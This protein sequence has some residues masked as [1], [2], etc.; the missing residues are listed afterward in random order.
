M[1]GAQARRGEGAGMLDRALVD[2]VLASAPFAPTAEQATV[3]RGLTA[4][5]HGVESVEA[6]AGTGKTFTAGLLAQAYAAGGLPRARDRADGTRGARAHRA[7]RHR[8]G[9]DA[10]APGARPRRRRGRLRA[11]VGGVDP[12]RGR[13]GE[14]PRN[15]ARHGARPRRRGEG[16]RDR[17]LRP[18]LKRPGRRLA[19]IAHPAPGLLRAAR[20][21]APA[22]PARA[23]AAGP[24]PPRRP[25]RLHHREAPRR[26]SAHH[27]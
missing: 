16:H 25:H 10:H 19:G 13:H 11:R 15:R 1:H 27:R 6:L 17:R 9:V 8:A 24:R 4:S 26:A 3:I 23:P 5:G 18:A 21:H 22:R 2:A 20:G 7:G 12:R 14:H